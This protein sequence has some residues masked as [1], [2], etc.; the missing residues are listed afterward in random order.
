MARTDTSFTMSAMIVVDLEILRRVDRRHALRRAAVFSSSGGMM[1]PTTTG[2]VAEPLALQPRQHLAHQ[3]HMR[4]RQDGEADECTAFLGGA[5]DL[6]G[7]QADAVVDDIHAGIARADRDLLGAV[8]MAVEA[9]LADQ[10]FQPP[11][12][13]QRDA[14]DLLAHGSRLSAPWRAR[15]RDAGR[16]AIFAED[17]AQAPRPIRRSSRRPWRRRSTAP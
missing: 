8:R 9:R 1:P 7:R 5:D 10:E 15:R 3:R 17:V 11:A 12:E 16:R 6:G 13:L 4:S 2:H 14:L